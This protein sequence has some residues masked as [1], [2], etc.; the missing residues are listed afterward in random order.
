VRECASLQVG[1]A[2][3]TT[4]VD[5]HSSMLREMRTIDCLL[6]APDECWM[7]SVDPNGPGI[8]GAGPVRVHASVRQ[9]FP[10]TR[11][12]NTITDYLVAR[13]STTLEHRNPNIASINLIVKLP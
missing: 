5:R 8:K 9:A 3:P 2:S 11:V 4:L 6:H 1:C 13:P 10:N 7:R 12:A